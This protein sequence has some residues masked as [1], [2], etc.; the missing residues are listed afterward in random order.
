VI[1]GLWGAVPTPLR[2]AESDPPPAANTV[3]IEALSRLKG[4][5]IEANPALKAAVLKVLASTRR[6]PAFV[7]IVQ[8]F[9]LQDQESGLIEV[10]EKHA[11]HSI[12]AE[13]ARLLLA[14]KDLIALKKALA[15][16]QAGAITQALGNSGDRLAVPLLSALISDARREAALRKL[17]VKGLAQTQEGAAWLLST[18]RE[19]KLPDDLKFTATSE[20]NQA[21]WPQIR[22]EAAKVLP[23]PSSSGAEPLP[24]LAELLQRKGDASK[25]AEVFRRETTGCIK[26]H[27]V[28]GEGIDFGPALSEI[29]SKLGK[30]AL[31]ESILDPSSGISFGYEAW[32]FD[33]KSGDEV[34][35]LIASETEE[36]VTVKI[37]GGLVSKHKKNEIKSRLQMKLSIMPAG[38]QQAMSVTDLVNLVE[39]LTELK[40]K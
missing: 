39:Y 36:E 26:C 19:E 25:G 38:L 11:A 27:Q 3:A 32:Q 10:I 6:T 17:A 14:Q 8:D 33:L 31:Y 34:F 35:G 40:K 15:G 16:A 28:L 23:P 29:G 5:D 7:Q 2:A 4:M 12:S 20:L 24:P 37:Q 1:G 22:A 18:V 30:D 21:R 13:A 9:K